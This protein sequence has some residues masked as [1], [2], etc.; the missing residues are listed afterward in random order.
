MDISRLCREV[1]PLNPEERVVLKYF[2]INPPSN[3][4]TI[5]K[6]TVMSE[7]PL[8]RWKLDRILNGESRIQGLVPTE[9]LLSIHEN[10]NR[11]GKNEKVYFL[12]VKGIIASLSTGIKINRNFVFEK[13]FA[14]IQKHLKDK[15]LVDLGKKY[16]EN[17]I[18]FFLLWHEIKGFQ[19]KKLPA[20]YAYY[21]IFV[22]KG[23]EDQ[24]S[25]IPILQSNKESVEKMKE[26]IIEILQ[27]KQKL[28]EVKKIK[29][30]QPVKVSYFYPRNENTV[31]RVEEYSVNKN[32]IDL[33]ID[34]FDN[35]E[36]FQM[37][38]HYKNFKTIEKD[39]FNIERYEDTT[40]K[41]IEDIKARL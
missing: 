23:W 37:T 15:A 35:I 40:E 13:Y 28:L 29:T 38:Q 5:S 25:T 16:V 4:T 7:N 1:F 24:L 9:F 39:I 22:N 17:Q 36:S 2:S 27:T 41:I 18:H 6:Y 31:S 19:L 33:I 26:I 14:F 30:Y 11:W 21:R 10:K 34:W 20:S 8:N 3:I 32:P 12:T